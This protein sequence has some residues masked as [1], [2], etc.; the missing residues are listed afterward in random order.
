MQEN[1]GE[2]RRKDR[3]GSFAA[4]FKA[5]FSTVR[6]KPS[7]IRTTLRASCLSLLSFVRIED[8]STGVSGGDDDSTGDTKSTNWQAIRKHFCLEVGIMERS[9]FEM[10]CSRRN[11]VLL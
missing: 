4:D 7:S 1:G 9:G 2:A 8:V 11:R 5:I 3:A 10:D 6:L